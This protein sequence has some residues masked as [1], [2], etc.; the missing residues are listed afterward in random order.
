VALPIAVD[1]GD[2]VALEQHWRSVNMTA[3]K[4]CAS[5]RAYP[6]M[7]GFDSLSRYPNAGLI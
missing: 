3:Q 1:I 4:T 2:S 7:A 5:R 6:C